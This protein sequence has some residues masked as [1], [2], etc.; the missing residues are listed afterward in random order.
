MHVCMFV[1]VHVVVV[2]R[3]VAGV[4]V[5]VIVFVFVHTHIPPS[6]FRLKGFI[7]VW[8]RF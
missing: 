7:L 1:Y 2:E 5:I 8:G 4:F 6:R 3:I